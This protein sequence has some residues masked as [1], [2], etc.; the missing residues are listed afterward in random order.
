[1]WS[2]WAWVRT[3]RS[4][5]PTPAARTHWDAASPGGP[6]S[7]M[8]VSP[9]ARTRTPAP[10]PT[11]HWTICQPSGMSTPAER[12]WRQM[13]AASS[14]RAVRAASGRLTASIAARMAKHA[15]NVA[16]FEIPDP[17][18]RLR[19]V[20]T[21]SI[22]QVH[23]LAGTRSRLA[24]PPAH[25]AARA[26]ARPATVSGATTGATS[27]FART[28]HAEPLSVNSARIGRHEICAARGM[29][30]ASAKRGGIRVA[31]WSARGPPTTMMP[32]VALA[33]R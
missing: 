18:Q 16:A 22:H 29:A 21:A 32:S 7:T 6:A 1:M 33:E 27:A 12:A 13:S 17:G 4:I 24:T 8:I 28:P 2:E 23:M 9:W 26:A 10:C 15:A 25:G 11:S 31:R 14:A 5:E 19:V 3:S 30:S 20:A